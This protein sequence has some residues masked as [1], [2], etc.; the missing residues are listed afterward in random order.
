MTDPFDPAGLVKVRRKDVES[1]R[2]SPVSPTPAGLLNTRPE[3]DV[4][5]LVAFLRAGGAPPW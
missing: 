2:P 1:V 3:A 5:D 4:L